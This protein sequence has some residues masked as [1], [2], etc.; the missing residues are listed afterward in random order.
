[1]KISRLRHAYP[2]KAGFLIHRKEGYHEYTLLHFFNS[3]ELRLGDQIIQT[4]PHAMILYNIGTPQYFK[5]NEPLI[6]DWMHFTDPAPDLFGALQPDTLYY[7]RTHSFI[8]KTIRDL[9]SEFY[10]TQYGKERLLQCKTEELFI[11]LNR[12]VFGVS[13]PAVSN[14]TE[15]VLRYLRG[16]IFSSLETP[17]TVEKMAKLVHMSPSRLYPV[18]KKVYGISPMADLINARINSAKNMLLFTS[19]KVEEIAWKLGY[20]NVTH[21]IRQFKK[22][23]GCTPAV[24]RKK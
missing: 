4:E 7:P 17:W 12:A 10:G 5:S 23:V 11:Q 8:T 19:E 1:M 21:F 15:K 16:T 6:H 18:Y 14:E 20:Q 3:V 13:A 9:E 24:Y 22:M 2:E